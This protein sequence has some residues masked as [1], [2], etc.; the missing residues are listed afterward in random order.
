MTGFDVKVHLNSFLRLKVSP[1]SLPAIFIGLIYLK[2][3]NSKLE[4][5]YDLDYFHIQIPHMLPSYATKLTSIFLA[6]INHVKIRMKFLS[7]ILLTIWTTKRICLITSINKG[8]QGLFNFSI[9]NLHMFHPT[10]ICTNMLQS[11]LIC[12]YVL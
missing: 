4:S 10:L 11:S 1:M 9:L 3:K 5:S 12:F 6:W 2:N 8:I 7:S